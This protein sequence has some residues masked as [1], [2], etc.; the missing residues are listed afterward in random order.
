MDY[1]CSVAP[2]PVESGSDIYVARQPILDRKLE[3]SG[4]ELLYRSGIQSSFPNERSDLATSKVING[5]FLIIG[6]ERLIGKTRAFI[7]FDQQVL[8]GALPLA[9]APDKV[10]IELLESVVADDAVLARCRELKRLGFKIALDDYLPSPMTEP[11]LALADYVKIDFRQTSPAE[12][13]SLSRDFRRRGIATVA[14]K[15]E[16]EEEYQS[17]LAMGYSFFQ[18]YFFA[19]PS[20]VHSGSVRPI[21]KNYLQLLQETTREELDLDRVELLL[22]HEPALTF[23]LL[24]YMN[25]AMFSW[26]A[27][28]RSVRHALVL[29]GAEELRKWAAI[30]VLCGMALD[31][32]P[33]LLGC[34]VVRA[35]LCELL[36]SQVGLARRSSE[37][38]LMGMFSLFDAILNRPLKDVLSELHLPPDIHNILLGGSDPRNIYHIYSL[39]RA[40]ERADWQNVADDAAQLRIP[41]AVVPELY[42]AAVDWAN[43]FSAQPPPKTR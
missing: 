38:F 40:L 2:P 13:L 29:L 36:G 42:C 15:I 6:I 12:R 25:S 10:V 22:K 3:V 27:E 16:T 37:L 34:A 1:Q 19:K 23:Q 31:R 41:E 20:T 18:G 21:K 5:A 35:R 30:V 28:I 7:N 43:E 32:P 33:A 8:L 4:Y 11:L 24:R 14:E 9:L 39:V 26:Q 17:A